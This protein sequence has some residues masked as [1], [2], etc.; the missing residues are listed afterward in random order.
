MKKLIILLLSLLISVNSGIAW[1][2]EYETNPGFRDLKPGMTFEYFKKKCVDIRRTSKYKC[3]DID[4]IFFKPG[5]TFKNKVRFIDVLK[6][7]MG[8][9]V[10]SDGT[11]FTILN[12]LVVEEPNIY[13]KMKRNFDKKYLLNYEYSERDR[14]LFNEGMKTDLLGVYSNGQVAVRIFRKPKEN[15]RSEDLWLYIEYR[16]IKSAEKFLERNRPVRTTLDDF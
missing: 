4:N 12:N 2:G 14:Q 7:D 10:K 5:S 16:D 8:P 1:G 13:L 6:L 3:Y 9:I 11:F 15:S